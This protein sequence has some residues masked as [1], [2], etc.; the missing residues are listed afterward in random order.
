VVEILAIIGA[1]VVLYLGFLFVKFTQFRTKLYNEFGRRGVSYEVA[2]NAYTIAGDFINSLHANG[3]NI[4][5]I[6]DE[7]MFR[8]PDLF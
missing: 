3:K 4:D 1:S 7:V 6:V 5:E 8:Y 2:D